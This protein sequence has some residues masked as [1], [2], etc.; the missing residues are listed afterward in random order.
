MI[1]SFYSHPNLSEVIKPPTL[2]TNLC[3]FCLLL[4]EMITAGFRSSSTCKYEIGVTILLFSDDKQKQVGQNMSKISSSRM[5]TKISERGTFTLPNTTH[6]RGRK[7][8]S[9]SRMSRSRGTRKINEDKKWC[10][11][12]V[13]PPRVVYPLTVIGLEANTRLCDTHPGLRW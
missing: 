9:P 11:G 5:P 10:V 4:L 2:H 12:C 7:V 6:T 3:Y 8:A 1:D 13:P